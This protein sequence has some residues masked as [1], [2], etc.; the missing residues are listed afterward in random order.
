MIFV[1]LIKLVLI[2]TLVVHV[3]HATYTENT[4]MQRLIDLEKKVVDQ[5]GVVALASVFIKG[6]GTSF[7]G[8]L[9]ANDPMREVFEAPV[10]DLP[11]GSPVKEFLKADGVHAASVKSTPIPTPVFSPTPTLP[12]M[13]HG[14]VNGPYT[15]PDS[16]KWHAH[17]HG[18]YAGLWT[19]EDEQ[20]QLHPLE[21]WTEQDGLWQKY[22][23]Q[24][25][26]EWAKIP[27]PTPTGETK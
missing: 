23:K 7:A 19:L 21:I 12:P 3:V 10:R 16:G 26:G 15:P 20:S 4:M 27:A 5:Q 14:R 18:P 1:R 9:A 8:P 24:P 22:K 6:W 13:A 25:N 11:D 17:M 2:F